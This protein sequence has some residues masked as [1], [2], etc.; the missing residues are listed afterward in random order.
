MAISHVAAIS[1]RMVASTPYL[2]DIVQPVRSG[3][4]RSVH[5]SASARK[6]IFLMRFGY[7]SPVVIKMHMQR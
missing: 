6:W 1:T 7:R 4:I 5:G 2:D 3:M